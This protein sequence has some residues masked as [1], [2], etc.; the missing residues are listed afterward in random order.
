MP[1]KL[2]KRH[3]SGKLHLS[4]DE[5]VLLMQRKLAVGKFLPTLPKLIASN[6]SED[7][8]TNSAAVF[9]AFLAA[10]S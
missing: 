4:K 10:I 1:Q 8:E 2:A 5:L 3:E 6:A 9:N 7:V